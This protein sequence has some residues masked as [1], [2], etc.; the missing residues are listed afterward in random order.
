[1]EIYELSEFER[2]IDVVPIHRFYQNF[3]Q[4]KGET[5]LDY[6]QVDIRIL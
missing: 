6:D 5:D 1:M 4:G 3:V 2:R